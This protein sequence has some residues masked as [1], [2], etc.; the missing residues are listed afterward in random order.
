MK[1][2]TASAAAVFFAAGSAFAAKTNTSFD[3]LLKAGPGAFGPTGYSERSGTVLSVDVTETPSNDG[4]GDGD[5]IVR[6]INVGAGMVI[7]GIGW[8]VSLSAIAPSWRS[9]LTVLVSD[10]TGTGGFNLTP[11]AADDTPGG[12]TTYTS[13]GRIL[14]LANYQIPDVIALADGLIRLE[15]Y[16]SY[17]DVANQTDGFWNSGELFLQVVPTPA[18]A[19]LLGLAG[20]GLLGRKRR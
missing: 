14:K 2:S 1:T 9:E 6:F 16:E 10:S 13:D 11:G 18:S 12:P 19:G 15:F 20:I 4:L 17:D 3:D 5:N 7:N 8:D